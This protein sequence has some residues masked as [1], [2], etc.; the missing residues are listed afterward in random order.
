MMKQPIRYGILSTASIVPRFVRGLNLT[1][2]AGVTAIASRSAEKARSMAELLEIP[3]YYDDYEKI[4]NHPEIDAVYIPLI[5]SLHYPYAKKALEAGMHVILEK[6][7][8]LHKSEAEELAVLAQEKHLFITEAVKTPFL[9]IYAKIRKIIEDKTYG[10]IQFMDFR[11]SYTSGPYIT[12]WNK[13]KASGGGVLIANEAYFFH[14]AEFLGGKVLS[15]SGNASYGTYDVEDQCTVSAK[16]ENDILATLSVS[17][18]VLFQNGLTIYLDRGRIEIPDFWKA[19]TAYIYSGD[20]L[21]DTLRCDCEYEFQYELTHYNSCIRNG[22]SF[23]PIT[24]VSNSARY[25][26]YCEE[27]YRSF[28]K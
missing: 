14:M 1:S 17:T 19:N 25:I 23:S 22:L 27:L 6:P 12:G 8:V 28:E 13:D 15:V 7:F 21:T 9:P 3:E 20:Q 11:Q 24:P 4:L 5:N 2:S 18:K 16:L 10:N 26:G